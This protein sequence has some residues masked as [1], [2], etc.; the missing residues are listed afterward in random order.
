MHEESIYEKGN[1]KNRGIDPLHK[2]VSC[3]INGIQASE[4]DCECGHPP[5][6]AFAGLVLSSCDS[7]YQT[8]T[9]LPSRQGGKL[10]AVVVLK[11]HG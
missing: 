7:S 4:P 10:L 9:C 2:V 8:E 5:M 6:A 3:V 11:H 1:G